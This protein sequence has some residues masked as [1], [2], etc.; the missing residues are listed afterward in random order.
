[1]KK[2]GSSSHPNARP[3]ARQIGPLELVPLLHDLESTLY[4]SEIWELAREIDP[5]RH[6]PKQ[7]RRIL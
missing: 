3:A 4:F 1:M 6:S 5:V 2:D 7:Q